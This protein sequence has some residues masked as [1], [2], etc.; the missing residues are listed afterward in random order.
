MKILKYSV[1]GTLAISALLTMTMPAAFATSNDNGFTLGYN[2][3]VMQGTIGHN[4]HMFHIGTVC[5]GQSEAWC[6]GFTDGYLDGFFQNGIPTSSSSSHTT[7]TIHGGGGHD[8]DCDHRHNDTMMSHCVHLP[9]QNGQ[10][11]K[12]GGGCE[13]NPVTPKCPTGNCPSS[14]P[15]C[16]HHGGNECGSTSGSM[17]SST[18]GTIGGSTSGSTGG[19]STGG[20]TSGGDT[21]SSSSGSSSNGGSSSG[22]SS[23]GSSSGSNSGSSGGSS[24]QSSSSPQ[25]SKMS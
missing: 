13:P 12:M 22:S 7:I 2:N 24:S 15:P 11:I 18:S 5:I 3:G 1:I 23:S 6:Q 20:S 16:I 10:I 4:A 9:C 25:P 21:G 19:S 8:H 14:S 17:G